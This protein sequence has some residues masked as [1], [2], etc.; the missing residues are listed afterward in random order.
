MRPDL[1]K[2]FLK[3]SDNLDRLEHIASI[4]EISDGTSP[5]SLVASAAIVGAEFIAA[6]TGHQ[7]DSAVIYR[8]YE[9]IVASLDSSPSIHEMLTNNKV[10]KNK[11]AEVVRTAS[12]HIQRFRSL[13]ASLGVANE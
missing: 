12:A 8:A 7:N 4:L 9:E 5:R 2:R 13:I 11:R 3:V 10:R 1:Q 6:A